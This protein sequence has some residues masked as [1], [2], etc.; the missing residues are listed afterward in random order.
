MKAILILI[1]GTS[2]LI[3][4][5]ATREGGLSVHM[6]PD[7]VAEISGQHGDFT[8]TEP[9]TK[10]PGATYAQP[11]ELLAYFHQ[12][13]TSVQQNGIWIVTTHPSSYSETEQ[14]TLKTLVT[15]C[16]A[17]KIPLYT[18]RASELPKG[19]RRAE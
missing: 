4:A 15:L 19:W 12:L 10:Q 9:A 18:C 6:L 17:E 2:M 3:A 16:A 13:P 5:E 14:A 8:V 11:K 1:L 7:R